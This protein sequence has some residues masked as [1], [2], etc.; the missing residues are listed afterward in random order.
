MVQFIALGVVTL[1]AGLRSAGAVDAWLKAQ[2]M[3][4]QRPQSISRVGAGGDAGEAPGPEKSSCDAAAAVY[5]KLL[6][7]LDTDWQP[8]AVLVR[9]GSSSWIM[10]GSRSG[11]QMWRSKRVGSERTGDLGSAR[12]GRCTHSDRAGKKCCAARTNAGGECASHT[13]RIYRS[14]QEPNRRCLHYWYGF[15]QLR[16]KFSCRGLREV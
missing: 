10:N 15:N 11:F 5:R 12:H 13:H 16:T 9:D 6:K 8:K 1:G 14:R 4:A 7:L 3:D 2:N